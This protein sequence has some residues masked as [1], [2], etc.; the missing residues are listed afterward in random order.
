MIDI[1]HRIGIKA[2]IPDVYRAL[3][4]VQGVAGWW[5]EETT[6]EATVGGTI[7]GTGARPSSSRRTAA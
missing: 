7:T 4:T 1:I 3:A 2:P 6:G 5:T